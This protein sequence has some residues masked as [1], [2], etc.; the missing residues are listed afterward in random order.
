MR[1]ACLLFAPRFLPRSRCTRNLAVKHIMFILQCTNLQ[2][3]QQH[4]NIPCNQSRVSMANRNEANK[5]MKYLGD[6]TVYYVYAVAKILK[7]M[8][9]NWNNILKQ[10]GDIYMS[11]KE[12]TFTHPH[13]YFNCICILNQFGNTHLVESSV[14]LAV[15]H[16]TVASKKWLWLSIMLVKRRNRFYYRQ[17]WPN[18][19]YEVALIIY[20]IL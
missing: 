18:Y 17:Q 11:L 20:I 1:H 7:V 6:I 15:R 8:L 4:H 12:D 3:K 13:L 19:S 5:L 14:S 16:Q 10:Y 9:K 2:N